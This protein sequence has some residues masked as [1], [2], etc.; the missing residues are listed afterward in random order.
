[1]VQDN[2][3]LHVCHRGDHPVR[4]LLLAFGFWGVEASQRAQYPLII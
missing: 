4:R 3:H 1:M 2:A